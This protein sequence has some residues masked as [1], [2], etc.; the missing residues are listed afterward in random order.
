MEAKNFRIGNLIY[1]KS[2]WNIDEITEIQMI[3]LQDI[4][5]GNDDYTYKRVPLTQ[6]ILVDNFGFEERKKTED[7]IIYGWENI[8]I[9]Y[10]RTMDNDYSF[11]LDGYHNDI[12]LEFVDEL[13]NLF[14]AIRKKEIELK[15]PISA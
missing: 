7:G 6:K 15:S 4:E 2:K 1:L 14:F 10:G 8:T 3:N 5:L 13:Q 11:F 12:Y 9:M